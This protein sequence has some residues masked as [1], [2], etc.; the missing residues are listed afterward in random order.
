MPGGARKEGAA[1]KECPPWT[2]HSAF[3]AGELDLRGL[4]FEKLLTPLSF[5]LT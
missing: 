3:Q 4:Q 1:R 5:D 2:L